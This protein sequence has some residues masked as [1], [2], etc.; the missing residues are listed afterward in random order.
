MSANNSSK[1]KASIIIANWNGK[2][3]LQD[4]LPS[5]IRA[6]E[7]DKGEHEIIVVDDGSTDGS[8]EFV[9]SKFP[10]VEVI[11][12]KKNRGFAQANNIAV[13]QSKNDFLIFLNNDMIVEHE[14]IKPLL[15][16]LKDKNLFAASSRITMSTIQVGD[17]RIK[18]TGLT[19]GRFER[20]FV[21][22]RQ[23][24]SNTLSSQPILYAG[25]GSFACPKKKFLELRGFATV[26]KPFYYEDTDLSY[27]AW[28]RGWKILYEPKSVVYH[29][30]RGTINP[31]NFSPQYIELVTKKNY[32]LFVWKNISDKKLLFQ[33]FFFLIFK[34]VS[35]LFKGNFLFI[36]AF[37]WALKQ[38]P[39]VLVNRF[40]TLRDAR[41]SD[42]EIFSSL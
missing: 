35:A 36:H 31:Q 18:E 1:R 26:Y 19:K 17:N 10:L 2:H 20:G 15:T 37:F 42:K 3:L 13:S 6:V 7:F 29:K 4:C 8:V 22:V 12:L 32:I 24:E 41:L 27:R 38:L 39:Q 9:K 34:L 21:E 40:F 30:Y 14:F 28:K 33:H 23:E 16:H 5:V 11:S 25:G